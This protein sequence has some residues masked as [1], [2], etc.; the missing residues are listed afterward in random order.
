M[1]CVRCG[2]TIAPREARLFEGGL[3]HGTCPPDWYAP[4]ALAVKRANCAYLRGLSEA[5][6]ALYCQ[7]IGQE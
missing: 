4:A 1:T 2:G 7:C 6:H 5:H 3:I